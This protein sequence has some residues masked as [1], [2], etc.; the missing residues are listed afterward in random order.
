MSNSR[1]ARSQRDHDPDITGG[2][3][4]WLAVAVLLAVAFFVGMFAHV[5]LPWVD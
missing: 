2:P 3:I 5:L 4:L 1:N